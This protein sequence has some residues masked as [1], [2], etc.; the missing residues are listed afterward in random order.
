MRQPARNFLV[1]I[2]ALFLQGI[3]AVHAANAGIIVI[4]LF[5]DRALFEA[6]LG[7][8]VNVVDFDDIDT[9]SSDPA[10]FAADLFKASKGI[11]ITGEGGQ[12]VSREFNF[13]THYPPVSQP[14]MYAPG[15]T[16]SIGSN[17]GSGGNT[18]V[19][20]FFT[21]NTPAQVAGFGAFFIDAD[22]PSLG[23][24]SLSVFG[25]GSQLL[26]STGTVSGPNA[27]QLFHGLVAIDGDTNQPVP[28]I[29]SAQLITGQG[30]PGVNANE[31]VTLDD[32][33]FGVP[34]VSSVPEPSTLL[35]LAA[36]LVGLGCRR[37]QRIAVLKSPHR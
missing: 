29:S 18:T 2:I 16:A 10:S 20:T 35:L 11:V 5:T 28:V 26:G 25:P 6:R 22:F 14:N 31:G 30:W 15:P 32:F 12:F 13:P 37:L 1:S 19:V 36:G 24:S 8:G 3:I 34:S 17:A 4:E 9:S 7:G 21:G 27:S 23:A 33:V